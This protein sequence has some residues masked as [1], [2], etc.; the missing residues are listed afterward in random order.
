MIFAVGW[1]H[2]VVL[3]LPAGNADFVGFQILLE[4]RGFFEPFRMQPD[5]EFDDVVFDDCSRRGGAD[6]A[7]EHVD[8]PGDERVRRQHAANVLGHQFAPFAHGVFGEHAFAHAFQ[9]AVFV[10]GHH[11]GVGVVHHGG[12]VA[13]GFDLHRP[14]A[15]V[16]G[17]S[18]RDHVLVPN[19][20]AVGGD[21]DGDGRNDQVGRAELVA[22]IPFVQIAHVRRRQFEVRVAEQGALVDP[23]DQSVDVLLGQA[24]V[25]FQ[26]LNADA[27]VVGVGGHFAVG[28]PVL[29][30]G[31]PGPDLLVGFESHRADAAFAMADHAILVDDSAGLAVVGDV[32][33]RR[34]LGVGDARREGERQ[35]KHRFRANSG[36]DFH[37][38]V[39][40]GQKVGGIRLWRISIRSDTSANSPK[41]VLN[42]RFP[43]RGFCVA[44]EI[45]MNVEDKLREIPRRFC[46]SASLRAE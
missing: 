27:V 42:G 26:F 7:G 33:V 18:A 23:G 31:R 17:Q 24:P 13:P 28:D 25:A 20:V 43:R 12:G 3:P 45:A 39:P 21:V 6:S 34:G 19:I 29:D 41:C 40:R 15:A 10:N 9:R 32:R 2:E 37:N 46:D 36:F 14:D 30:Q 1:N 8:V 4:R 5:A 38:R 11:S 16:L 35:C 44:L 22:E